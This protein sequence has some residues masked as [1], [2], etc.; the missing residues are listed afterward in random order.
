MLE[1][2]RDEVRRFGPQKQTDDLTLIVAKSKA[3][4]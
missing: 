3:T 1:A 2:V 4:K